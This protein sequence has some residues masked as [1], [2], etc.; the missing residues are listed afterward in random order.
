MR[1][2]CHVINTRGSINAHRSLVDLGL[3]IS[4]TA[5]VAGRLYRKFVFEYL[6]HKYSVIICHIYV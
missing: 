2:C 3:L 1:H 5:R 6:I 4:D